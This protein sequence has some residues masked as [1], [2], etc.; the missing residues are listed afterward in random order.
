MLN[1]KKCIW[2]TGASTGIGRSLALYLA[3][4]GFIVAASAR[5]VKN[6]KKLKEDSKLL[7]GKIYTYSLDIRLRN[8][9]ISTFNKIEKNLGNIGVVILNAAIN[10]PINVKNFSSKRIEHLMNV[11][12]TGTVNCL[13]PII[14]KFV[15]RKSGKIAIVASLAGYIGFPYSSG[16]CPTKAA[17]ISICES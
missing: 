2:I 3:G 12:Y 9:V 5:S 1:I 14:K 4:K 13:D 10:E 6:L 7:K 16:Y 11:N 15:K 17:L 8:N